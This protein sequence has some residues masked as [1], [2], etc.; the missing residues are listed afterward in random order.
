VVWQK[1]IENCG[2]DVC[3]IV[4]GIGCECVH[5]GEFWMDDERWM[6][7]QDSEQPEQALGEDAVEGEKAETS[8]DEWVWEN[9]REEMGV[10]A[11]R[12]ELVGGELVCEKGVSHSCAC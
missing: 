2:D 12:V 7:V 9:I 3:E 5:G 1:W 10:A 6:V 4:T 11:S 8:E